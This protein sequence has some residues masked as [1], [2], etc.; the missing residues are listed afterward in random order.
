MQ[1]ILLIVALLGTASCGEAKENKGGTTN[2]A[3]AE[4]CNRQTQAMVQNHIAMPE[5]ATP[6]ALTNSCIA[7]AKRYRDEVTKPVKGPVTP[8]TNR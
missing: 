7:G 2:S 8:A 1:K 4:S 6:E 5:G 3:I